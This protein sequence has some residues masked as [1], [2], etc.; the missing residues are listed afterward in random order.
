MPAEIQVRDLYGREMTRL[1][2]LRR[3]VRRDNRQSEEWQK[4]VDDL[5]GELILELAKAAV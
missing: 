1:D 3:S 5:I 2:R 4:R